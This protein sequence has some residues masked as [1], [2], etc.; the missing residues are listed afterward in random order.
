MEVVLVTSTSWILLDIYTQETLASP[1]LRT[2]IAGPYHLSYMQSDMVWAAENRGM[3]TT[4]RSSQEPGRSITIQMP[5]DLTRV[6]LL[7]RHAWSFKI[8]R[9]SL[10]AVVARHGLDSDD[11]L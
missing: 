11:I 9:S 6:P 5:A 8:C 3:T 7:D 2:P 1:P 4:V 10:L